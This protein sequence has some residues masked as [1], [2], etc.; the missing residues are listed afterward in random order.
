MQS[1]RSAYEAN[2]SANKGDAKNQEA[3][4]RSNSIVVVANGGAKVA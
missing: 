4:H 2:I 3:H 1:S